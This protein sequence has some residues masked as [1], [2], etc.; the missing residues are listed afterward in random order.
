MSWAE[1]VDGEFERRYRDVLRPA[2]KEASRSISIEVSAEDI[3]GGV[4]NIMSNSLVT[5][6]IKDTLGY[7]ETL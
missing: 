4:R 7:R 3:A 1:K 5:N 6:A 2:I